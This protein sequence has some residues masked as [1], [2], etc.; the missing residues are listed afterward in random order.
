MNICVIRFSSLGDVILTQPITRW[1]RERWPGASVIFV[2]KP[3]NVPVALMFGTVDRIV[4]WRNDARATAAEIGE[5]DLTVDL[6]AKLNSWL[7]CRALK[8][9]RTV[10]YNK[11][12][13]TRWAI[14]HGFGN[15]A[16]DT[17]LDLYASALKPLGLNEKLPWPQLH[18]DDAAHAIDELFVQYGVI[19]RKTLI[20]VF[21]GARHATKRYPAEY[22]ACLINRVPD[23]WNC[24][25][26]LCGSS[27]DKPQAVD[28]LR[29]TEGVIDLTGATD[30]G[31]LARLIQRLDCVISNDSGPM[32][33]A[34][35]LQKPQIALFGATHPRLGFRPLN[36]NAVVVTS[37]LRCQP[38]SLHG[39]KTC[40][41]NHFRCLRGV[42]PAWLAD[43]FRHLLEEQ[44]WNLP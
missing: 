4:E 16:I 17:T 35:A 27:D 6:Q 18:P 43:K 42:H 29:E 38:C 3:V 26:L 9:V 39:G 22:F 36:D 30:T 28:I 24:Q 10:R 25:F 31:G 7:L 2:T 40:P 20:G 21:P 5:I 37:D 13:L 23:D 44:V 19:P 11:R 41:R 1:L 34:A 12:R 15:A 14:V 8:S 32:H 33:I